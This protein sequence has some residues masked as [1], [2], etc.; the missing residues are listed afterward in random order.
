M[1]SSSLQPTHTTTSSR[2]IF[3]FFEGPPIR[4]VQ[5]GSGT[6]VSSGLDAFFSAGSLKVRTTLIYRTLGQGSRARE[7]KAAR[8]QA[9]GSNSCSI[10]KSI[11]LHNPKT[12]NCS[13]ERLRMRRRLRG[14]AYLWDLRRL[15]PPVAK[16]RSRG[17]AQ[18]YS[19]RSRIPRWRP[20]LPFSPPVAPQRWLPWQRNND[21]RYN[22]D[23]KRRRTSDERKRHFR[24]R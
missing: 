16:P 2:A 8:R 13:G 1:P 7:A 14:F 15:V 21:S 17:G 18:T 23:G 5:G 19:E 9:E 22:V 6:R 10:Y 11:S 24:G 12:G 3:P 20:E 4:K